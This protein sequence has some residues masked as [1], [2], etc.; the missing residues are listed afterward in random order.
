MTHTLSNRALLVTLNIS[1]W[2][3]RKLDRKETEELARKHGTIADIARVNKSL[4]PFAGSL[5]K[6]HKATGSIRTYHYQQTLPWGQEGSRIIP[7]ANYM[8]FVAEM[9][10]K[11]SEWN[12]LVSAFVSDYPRLKQEAAV[13]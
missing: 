11:I 3:A 7:A 2:A 1:Q 5:E 6:I 12:R 10:N 4:L 8:A 13:L 9:R